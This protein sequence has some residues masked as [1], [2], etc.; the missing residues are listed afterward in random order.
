MALKTGLLPFKV[1]L[2]AI[3]VAFIATANGAP[4]SNLLQD[5]DQVEQGALKNTLALLYT[6]LSNFSIQMNTLQNEDIFLSAKIKNLQSEV[7]E[8]RT[9]TK[10]EQD[11]ITRF[12]SQT[13]DL[14][15]LQDQLAVQQTE[16][17]KLFA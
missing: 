5:L 16:D 8:T 9:L 11:L 13:S 14:S 12:A 4:R 3:V 1:I 17:E 2:F 10:S 7:T 15:T 6:S